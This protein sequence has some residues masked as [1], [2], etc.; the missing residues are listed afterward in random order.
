M[1]ASYFSQQ[2][3]D[4]LNAQ[5]VTEALPSYT[6]CLD[7]HRTLVRRVR[8]LGWDLHPLWERPQVL[9]GSSVAGDGAATAVSMP[10]L[11]SR[12]QAATV[13]RMMGRDGVSAPA[14]VDWRR[15]PVLEVRLMPE[16]LAVEL[17]L[18]PSAWWDQRNLI[19][20]LSIPRHRDTLRSL[21]TRIDGEFRFGFWH[22]ASL[23]DTSLP[24]RQILRANALLDLLGTFGD[25]QDWLRMGV[26]Y[27]PEDARLGESTAATEIVTAMAALYPLYA[28]LLWTS[29]NN[30]QSFHPANA[31]GYSGR[32]VNV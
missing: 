6:K 32:E 24:H 11:R 25:G 27:A 21:I 19:G 2:D 17:V 31:G 7:L 9:C 18:P 10:F 26:W 5:P 30:F 4:Q 13:E 1:S 29:N 14:S 20:K 16:H 23:S 8:E 3:H 15:H 12:E 28:F 22:G